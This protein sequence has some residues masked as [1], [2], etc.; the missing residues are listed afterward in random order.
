[1]AEVPSRDLRNNS[2]AVL[3]RVEEGEDIEITV[4]G[5]PVA[6]LVPPP[7]A[8]RHWPGRA[9]LVRRPRIDQAD[10]GLR[11]DLAGNDPA[12]AVG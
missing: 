11:D 8:R 2:A 4:R 9:E 1:M 7:R 3:R 5:R 12:G 6:A 10:P